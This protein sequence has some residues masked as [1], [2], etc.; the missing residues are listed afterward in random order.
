MNVTINLTRPE[1]ESLALLV[2]EL[3]S[4]LNYRATKTADDKL[5]VALNLW[6]KVDEKIMAATNGKTRD[7]AGCVS[8]LIDVIKET[9]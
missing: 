5:F 2:H 7:P 8:I 6:E 9:R 1:A 3:Q 4:R